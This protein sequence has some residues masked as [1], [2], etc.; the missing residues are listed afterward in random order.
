MSN[1]L[2]ADSLSAESAQLQ[3]TIDALKKKV[4]QLECEKQASLQQ[5]EVAAAEREEFFTLSLDVL[6]V[7]GMDGY[8]KRCNPAFKKILGYSADELTTQPFMTFVHP[9][10]KAATEEE[11]RKLAVG[12]DTIAFENR[13]RCK[14]GRYRWFLWAAKTHLQAQVIYATGRDITERKRI[15]QDLQARVTQ[16]ATVAELGQLALAADDL[17]WLMT[18][19]VTATAQTLEVEYCKI[20]E[21][22]TD[23]ETL[24]FKA[25]FGWHSGLVGQTSIGTDESS[26]SGYTL[27]CAHPVIVENLQTETRFSG[28]PLLMDHN[29]I[30]GMSVIIGSYHG[31][32][33][34]LGVHSTRR[35]AFSDYDIDF[36]QSVAN[37][38]AQTI[39]RMRSTQVLKQSELEYRMLTE[40]LPGIVYRLFPNNHNHMVFLNSQCKVLTG[41][42][43]TELLADGICSIDSLI[44]PEDFET[45]KTAVTQ[46]IALQQPFQSEYRIKNKAGNIRYFWEKGQPV[47]ARGESPNHVDGL[48]LDIT[49]RKL[50]QQQV[51]EQAALLEVATDAIFV[52]SMDNR[53]LF[54]NKGAEMLYGWCAAEALGKNADELL[55]LDELSEPTEPL[56]K[57]MIQGQWQGERQ[58]VTR[59]GQNITVMSRWTL[60]KNKHGEPASILT[61]NTDITQSKQLEAQFLRAQRLES[62]G[63]LASGIAHDLNNILTPI[64]GVAQLLPMQLPNAN[65]QLQQQFEI[66]QTSAKRGS[67]LIGQ[68]LSFARGVEGD[69]T[70]IQI[71]YLIREI[72]SFAHKTFPKSIEIAVDVPS[73]LWSVS[74]DATQLH[75][76]FMNLFVNAR[77]AMSEG[78]RLSVSAINLSLDEAL[79][80]KHINAKP[81][82]YILVTVADTGKGIPAEERDLIFEPFFTT[83]QA[84]G[85]TG[86]GLSTVH[87]I[88]NSHGGFITV[89]SDVG[90]GSQFKIYLPAIES[91]SNTV[92]ADQNS[93]TGQGECILVVDD[94]AAICEIV[95]SV[96]EN[97]HYQVLLANDGMDAIAQYTER[98]DDIHLVVMDMM[99]PTL[100]GATAI[101]IMQKIDPKLR[102]ILI[103]GLPGNEQVAASVGKSVKGFLQKP[104]SSAA[105]LKAVHAG[106]HSEADIV[107]LP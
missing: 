61:V 26:Q 2:S 71:R 68:V 50:A 51:R 16:Q 93:P 37:L 87:S 83:K 29:V 17:G 60:V 104:F 39:E 52:R 9:E 30:S 97:N 57:L 47:P 73:S 69:R 103:S 94:E 22:L 80:A 6:C 81:G 20:L 63:T 21:L 55:S 34:V 43:P 62:I 24:F 95:R 38:I 4:S 106:L 76:V 79:A 53:V 90:R 5:Q 98:K 42:D 10:D 92:E 18:K 46:A 64:Y 88:V 33:G 44:L 101:Q 67:E 66:L 105:L 3:K 96:L 59:T 48:I 78:G 40:N 107:Q 77:D 65:E 28:P 13:Y 70:P 36:L 49:D 11:V 85:G 102:A 25:G 23:G 15:E 82:P 1:L 14:D 7:A 58:Q 91:V 75:Q 86:L 45:V 32:Y 27:R 54:W 56:Q 72:R 35:R 41:F 8:F 99:M 74:G 12:I 84:K 89:S 100:S 19:I 31:P